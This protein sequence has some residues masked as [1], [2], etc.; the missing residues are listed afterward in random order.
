VWEREDF[1]DDAS[2]TVFRDVL[3]LALI[4]FVGIVVMLLPQLEQGREETGEQRSPGNVVVEIT[5]PDAL[6]VDVDLWVK[7]PG[8]I[9]VG[10][11]NQG[12]RYFN[13]LR[14]DRGLRDDATERNF[15]VS[16]SRGIP[17]GE[18]TVNVHMYGPLAE[19]QSVPINVV[20]SVRKRHE[21]LRQLLHRRLTLYRQ[22]QEET[23]FRFRL[24]DD[25]SLV[26]NSLSRLRRR[27][28]TVPSMWSP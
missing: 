10:F 19:G 6:P 20:V 18:Y 15:E 12:G 3:M 16:Y 14:D 27:L 23:A 17:T 2:N 4:G 25:G 1:L 21:R 7:A 11:F 9:P 22:S 13:L 28:V 24:D 26:P 5:W 8:D